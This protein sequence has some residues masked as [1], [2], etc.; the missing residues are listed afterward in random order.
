MRVH[1][2]PRCGDCGDKIQP[3]QDAVEIAFGL[4][5]HAGCDREVCEVCGGDNLDPF[6]C[7]CRSD[8]KAELT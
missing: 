2:R 4:F 5:R 6:Y 1:D 3:D 8:T 7:A